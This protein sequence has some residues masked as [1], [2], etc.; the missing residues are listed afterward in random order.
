MLKV[1]CRGS[2]WNLLKEN[3]S[4]TK[5]KELFLEFQ[6]K[7]HGVIERWVFS[8]IQNQTPTPHPHPLLLNEG[9][10]RL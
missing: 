8:A 3:G 4:K 9:V 7:D 5:S 6:F 1:V 10:G 2:S